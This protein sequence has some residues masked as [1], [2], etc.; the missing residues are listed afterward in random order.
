MSGS[1]TLSADQDAGYI[2][3]IAQ[4]IKWIAAERFK[5]EKHQNFRAAL[6]SVNMDLSLR[7]VDFMTE[8]S[9][10]ERAMSKAS[11]VQGKA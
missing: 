7:L 5:R 9:N 10:A 6:Y 8:D 3:T 1:N 2:E 11:Q 4:T